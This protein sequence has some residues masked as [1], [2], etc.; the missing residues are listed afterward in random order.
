MDFVLIPAGTFLM[1]SSENDGE[2]AANAA[3]ATNRAS[4]EKLP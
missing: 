2:A 3:T 1:G 4:G